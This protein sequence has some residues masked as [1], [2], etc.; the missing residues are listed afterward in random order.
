MASIGDENAGCA[1][2][3][4][5]GKELHVKRLQR[6]ATTLEERLAE[7]AKRL[8]DKAKTLPP[9]EREQALR[10]ARQ[11]ETACHVNDWINSPA[12]NRQF[13]EPAPLEP[14]FICR[15]PLSKP[16][17]REFDVLG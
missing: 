15:W 14:P 11:I 6:Q 9:V 3:Y 10:K 13:R 4:L 8:R 16:L 2:A 7:E 12:F 17:H 1:P 5:S